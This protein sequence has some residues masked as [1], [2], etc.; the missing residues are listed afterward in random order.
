MA[1]RQ[2]KKKALWAHTLQWKTHHCPQKL[3]MRC[4]DLY[5]FE[6]TSSSWCSSIPSLD[7][8]GELS[9]QGSEP[10]H[11]R[12]QVL[13]SA[14]SNFELLALPAETAGKVSSGFTRE[15]QSP[16]EIKWTIAV[17]L[18]I[19]LWQVAVQ[20]SDIPCS[21][22]DGK[23]A[24]LDTQF[25]SGLHGSSAYG[26]ENP[27][28]GTCHVAGGVWHERPDKQVL[29][30]T[31]AP[32]TC[33]AKQCISPAIP[34]LFFYFV[35]DVTTTKNAKSQ[36]THKEKNSLET[37]SVQGVA[38]W[39]FQPKLELLKACAGICWWHSMCGGICWWQCQIYEPFSVQELMNTC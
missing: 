22:L 31:W 24:H 35:V 14:S 33:S 5:S 32:R 13:C 18:L 1:L 12:V 28:E 11:G 34:F 4:L 7:F 17:A 37:L 3:K 27:E 15:G 19:G 29:S 21:R 16:L 38:A 9:L 23:A 6:E 25:L 39:P 2:W 10:G 8:S 26:R 20:Q 36:P 30:R